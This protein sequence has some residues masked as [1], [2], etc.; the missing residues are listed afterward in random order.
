MGVV[1]GGSSRTWLLGQRQDGKGPGV[2]SACLPLGYVT[3][4]L[5]GWPDL[6]PTRLCSP[7]RER[8]C[9]TWPTRLLLTRAGWLAPGTSSIPSHL[10]QPTRLALTP[11]L[12]WG[13]REA[14]PD[15]RG[16]GRD[17]IP[18]FQGT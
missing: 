14:S 9:T 18:C 15:A 6:I 17:W 8:L 2:A 1:S 16:G 13:S 3:G 11:G 10:H 12:P 7:T 4:P 5:A